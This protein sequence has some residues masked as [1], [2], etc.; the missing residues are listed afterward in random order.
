[1]LQ[2]L[3]FCIF[4]RLLPDPLF[5]LG[6]VDLTDVL[7]FYNRISRRLFELIGMTGLTE[8]GAIFETTAAICGNDLLDF[9]V[10]P[11]VSSLRSP[12]CHGFFCKVCE[13]FARL[14]PLQH[15]FGIVLLSRT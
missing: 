8:P 3:H 7:Q 14:Q 10:L 9:Q 4:Q 12:F 11:L 1:M 2:G 15:L 6:A 5:F 13:L